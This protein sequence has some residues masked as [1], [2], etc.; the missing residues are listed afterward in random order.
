MQVTGEAMTA[1]AMIEPWLAAEGLELDDVELSGRVLRVL[2]D[3]DGGIAVDRLAE[4]SNGI[5]RLIEDGLDIEG[6]YQLEV[7][8]P[9]LE[10]KLKRPGHF[11]KSVG[12]EVIIKTRVDGEAVALR[13]LLEAV[14]D[15][16][17]WVS[18]DSET[19]RVGFDDVMAAKTVFTWEK[20]PKPGKK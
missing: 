15:T 2:V 7:S 8:S 10:R 1:W 6:S 11:H 17:F 14:D 4:V 16:G 3:C 12:R 19:H 18:Q 5:S 9:G 20:A 13:G